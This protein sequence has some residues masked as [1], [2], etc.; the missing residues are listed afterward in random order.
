M[1]KNKSIPIKTKILIVEDEEAVCDMLVYSL[2]KGGFACE[3]VIDTKKAKSAIESEKPDLIILDW[4]LPNIS[5]IDYMRRLRR[6][7]NTQNIPIIML[8]AKGEEE[9]KVQGL[10]EGA[11]D[12]IVKPFKAKELIAR[13]KAVLR[14]YNKSYKASVKEINGL[15]L[16]YETHRVDINGQSV[17][18]GPTEFKLLHFFMEHPERVYSRH[19]LLDHVWGEN[20]YIEERTIDVHIRRLRKSLELYGFDSYIQTVHSVGY[21]FSWR[22]A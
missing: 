17:D 8:T 22:K 3:G 12:Y 5:G 6:D 19:Q 4:M 20:V 18:I 14:R 9:D 13:I 1:H 16:D 10:E 21:R 15:S 11:D 7:I 2:S